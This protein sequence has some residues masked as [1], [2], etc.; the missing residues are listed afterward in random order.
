MSMSKERFDQLAEDLLFMSETDSPLDYF[1]LDL[2]QSKQWPPSRGG[3]FSSL[4]GED[5]ETKVEKFA[6]EKFFK[7]LRQGNEDSEDQV[8]ALEKAMTEELQ[9]LAG[10]RVGEIEIHI[11]VLGQDDSGQ[12][13]GLQTLSVET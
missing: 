11:Y 12:A 8:A 6:P 3:Q 4:I 2:E 7:D 10:F 9:N 13:V 1:E 5:P